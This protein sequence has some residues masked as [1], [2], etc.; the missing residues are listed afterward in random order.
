VDVDVDLR[1]FYTKKSVALAY[2][3]REENASLCLGKMKKLRLVKI[4]V[5]VVR[6]INGSKGKII[7][8]DR[9]RIVG[10]SSRSG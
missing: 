7:I 3:S 6:E 8:G 10:G 5:I 2:F 1:A 9:G 4:M